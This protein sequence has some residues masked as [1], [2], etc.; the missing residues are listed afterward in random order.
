VIDHAPRHY[1]KEGKFGA[2]S[3]TTFRKPNTKA[4]SLGNGP[5]ETEETLAV[6]ILSVTAPAD[7][8]D[9]LRA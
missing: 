1:V 9:R 6:P 8:E 5:L 4:L 3:R 7:V 2:P